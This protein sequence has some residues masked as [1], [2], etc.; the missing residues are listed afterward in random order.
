MN[1]RRRIPDQP[2]N[3]EQTK[4][5]VH[6]LKGYH[7][8][9]ESIEVEYKHLKGIRKQANRL[10]RETWESIERE[11]GYIREENKDFG[12]NRD[13]DNFFPLTAKD[14]L[15]DIEYIRNYVKARENYLAGRFVNIPLDIRQTEQELTFAEPTAVSIYRSHY[16]RERMQTP[17]EPRHGEKI[18]FDILIEQIQY[19]RDNYDNVSVYN[20]LNEDGSSK[21][22]R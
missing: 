1:H 7:D 8:E 13:A 21:D 5:L 10:E 2:F 12:W 20:I 14:D 19:E 16:N 4:A 3:A 18:T 11:R 17:R 22:H 6:E 9:R 15:E